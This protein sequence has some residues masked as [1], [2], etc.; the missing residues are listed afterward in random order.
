MPTMHEKHMALVDA[1]NNEPDERKR[2]EARVYLNGWRACIRDSGDPQ[3]H[4]RL[5]LLADMEQVE[6]G[7]NRPT[8][9]G[10]F[11]CREEAADA[12]HLA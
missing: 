5:I 3:E 12:Q 7:H 10:V 9:G 2:R 1:V 8:C 11:L 6:R 4:G